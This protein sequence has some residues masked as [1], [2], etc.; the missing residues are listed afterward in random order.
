MSH[1]KVLV[2]AIIAAII[3]VAVSGPMITSGAD[4]ATTGLGLE[5]ATG[6]SVL[7][8]ASYVARLVAP[9]SPSAKEIAFGGLLI[10]VA[11]FFSFSQNLIVDGFIN[12]PTLPQLPS[13]LPKNQFSD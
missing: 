7:L 6:V 4:V 2:P 9:F 13:I 3:L 8:G 5:I 12:L 11:G 1:A 10:A